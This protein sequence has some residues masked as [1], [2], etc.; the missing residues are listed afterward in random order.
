M[1]SIHFGILYCLQG[2]HINDYKS[3][4]SYNT[5]EQDVV[6]LRHYVGVYYQL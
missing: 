2:V 6:Y 5:V 1:H 3:V 4:L